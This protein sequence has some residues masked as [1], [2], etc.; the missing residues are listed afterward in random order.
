MGLSND[1]AK[2]ETSLQIQNKFH[3]VVSEVSSFV[4]VLR[5]R[6]RWIR[7]ILAS[8]IRIRKNMRIHGLT[9]NC[10]KNY[11]LLSEKSRKIIKQFCFVKKF[12]N[13]HDLDQDPDKFFSSTEPGSRSA[14]N[15]LL[16]SS[17]NIVLKF[18]IFTFNFFILAMSLFLA[19]LFSKSFLQNTTVF[20]K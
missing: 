4:A 7:N 3:T 12:R 13:V 5:I 17:F 20:F 9:K 6:S 16:F 8:W 18:P 10:P 19:S 1:L 14:T 2:K 11:L 15:I